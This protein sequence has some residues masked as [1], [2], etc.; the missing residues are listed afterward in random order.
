MTDSEV[1]APKIEFPCVDYPIKII[2]N[3][4]VGFR[5]TVV[6]IVEKHAVVNHGKN[7][8]RLSTNGKY[9]TLQLHIVATGQEQLYDINSEL[10]ATG[11]VQMV[12]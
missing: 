9:T 8:E 10:R 2:G 4:G 11:I 7:A 5:D 3:T 12:L 1:K 6:E